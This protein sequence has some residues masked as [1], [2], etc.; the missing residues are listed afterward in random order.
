MS[1]S[2][3][4]PANSAAAVTVS[5]TVDLPD[6]SKSLY[7]GTGGN[8]KVKMAQSLQ[9][10]TFTNV[11]DGTVLP[12]IVTRVFDTGTTASSIVNLYHG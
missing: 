11:Q 8:V 6:K 9:D 3:I 1:A 5:D 12:I 10:V 2:A 4:Y 7:V